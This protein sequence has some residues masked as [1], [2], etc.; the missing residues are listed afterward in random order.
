MFKLLCPIEVI[1]RIEFI[2]KARDHLLFTYQEAILLSVVWWTSSDIQL[3]ESPDSSMITFDSDNLENKALSLNTIQHKLIDFIQRDHKLNQ[4]NNKLIWR[5]IWK[6][7]NSQVV[8][9]FIK[10]LELLCSK[11]MIDVID[12]IEWV[13][14][15]GLKS[16]IK[17]FLSIL[18]FN[19]SSLISINSKTIKEEIIYNI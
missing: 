6:W 7:N 18:W 13:T 17:E 3:N 12:F 19:S 4:P 5:K 1:S 11:N 9:D 14:S 2:E 10:S 15:T 8:K 16:S